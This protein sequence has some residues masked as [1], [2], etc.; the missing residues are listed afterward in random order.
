MKGFVNFKDVLKKVNRYMDYP[1][2]TKGADGI[3]MGMEYEIDLG[4]NDR[5]DFYDVEGYREVDGDMESYVPYAYYESPGLELKTAICSLEGHREGYQWLL[6]NYNLDA[7][8]GEDYNDG[9]IH[10]NT[11]V[12]SIGNFRSVYDHLHDKRNYKTF[13]SMSGRTSEQFEAWAGQ[14]GWESR[15]GHCIIINSEKSDRYEMRMY[16]ARTDLIIPAFEHVHSLFSLSTQVESINLENWS[17]FIKD[18]PKYSNINKLYQ[19]VSSF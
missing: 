16:R 12:D 14:Y 8:D 4:D 1:I 2:H 5:E 7:V 17:N 11:S 18:D 3:W 9:G 15:N 6:E 10:I 13:L 19:S